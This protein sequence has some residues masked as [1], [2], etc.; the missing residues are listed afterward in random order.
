MKAQNPLLR[1][2]TFAR[3]GNTRAYNPQLCKGFVGG[4]MGANGLV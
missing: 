1:L 4:L 3:R 2:A